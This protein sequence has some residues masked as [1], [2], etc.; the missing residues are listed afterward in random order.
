[1]LLIAKAPP[2]PCGTFLQAFLIQL[3]PQ[4]GGGG[5]ISKRFWPQEKVFSGDP[6]TALL[7]FNSKMFKFLL[8]LLLQGATRRT[9]GDTVEHSNGCHSTVPSNMVIH[10]K[11]FL[12]N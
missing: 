10:G 4:E 5:G 2:L 3:S 8:P 7:L 12:E 11:P 9:I 6:T 1:M